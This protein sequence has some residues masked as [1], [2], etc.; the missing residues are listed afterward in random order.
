MK[1][2]CGARRR[3]GDGGK[4]SPERGEDEEV[5]EEAGDAGTAANSVE[6]FHGGRREAVKLATA[7]GVLGL[8]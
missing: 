6:T 7:Q 4:C 5:G 2:R 3:P 1:S 8:N